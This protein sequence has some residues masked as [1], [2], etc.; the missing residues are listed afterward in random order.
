MGSDWP[1]TLSKCMKRKSV[2]SVNIIPQTLIDLNCFHLGLITWLWEVD[3][4]PTQACYAGSKET[5]FYQI[6]WSNGYT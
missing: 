4:C 2:C 1:L 3:T 5:L 6:P